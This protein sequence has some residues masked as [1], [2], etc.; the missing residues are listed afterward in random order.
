MYVTNNSFHIIFHLNRMFI[1][2]INKFCKSTVQYTLT[3]NWSNKLRKLM[4]RL[5]HSTTNVDHT[6]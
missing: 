6:L 3:H 2:M 5:L 4:F 1:L